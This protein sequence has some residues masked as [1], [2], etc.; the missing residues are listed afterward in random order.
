MSGILGSLE[1]LAAKS[2]GEA[3][4]FGLGFA[5]GRALEPAGVGLAQTAWDVDPNKVLAAGEAAGI[6]AEG[7]KD[8]GW[9]EAE[10]R[11]TGM[12]AE[13]FDA[14]LQEVLNGPGFA[15]LVAM[16][17]RGTITPDDFAHGLRKAKLEGRWNDPLTELQTERLDP[18]VVAVSVQRGTM[19]DPGLLPVDA[20]TEVG[21]VPPMPVSP[22][23]AVAEAAAAGVDRE[24]L[25]VMT[26]NVGL[27]PGPGELLQLLNRGVILEADVRRGIAEGNTRN[28]WAD[29]LLELRRHLITPA[30]YAELRVRGWID[31]PAME[32]GAALS[33][34]EAADVD[35]LF[36]LHGRPVPVHQVTTGE[37][38]G[39]TYNGSP[40]DIPVA[41][42]RSL[43]EGSL[44]PEWYS[45]AYANR[46]SYPSAFVLRALA[47]S[48]E[49]SGADV[50]QALLDIGWPPDLVAKVVQSWSG[51][52]TGQADKNVVKAQGELWT[53]LH[54]AYVNSDADD[55]LARSTLDALG[56]A[57]GSQ[58]AILALWV[59]E[60][61]LV[62]LD[63]TPTQIKKGYAEA[64]FTQDDALQRLEHLGMS[65]ADA[66][67][68]LAE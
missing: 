7:V 11:Q 66:A 49:L 46:Y 30:E 53:A 51:G 31:T 34:M 4:A 65:P 26:R 57:G 45:L 10:A 20:P 48:G 42:L 15:E 24:R 62:R 6:V 43:E 21:R 8:T 56:I 13:R 54:K 50:S 29:A 3:L 32:A 41:Y 19:T 38:R 36:S 16:L 37:A 23:D 12:N 55:G 63:L 18:A 47:T 39:G 59:R 1:E 5:L 67:T 9:G 52:T 61:G 68:L 60:R 44:R 28:E 14:L 22:L 27:P 33:G 58:T 17:R 40:A 25:A 2:A 35:L 64:K